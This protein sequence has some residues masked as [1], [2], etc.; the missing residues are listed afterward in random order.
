MTD[1]LH[2]TPGQ[3]VEEQLQYIGKIQHR[4]DHA[5]RGK[6][7]P[8][9]FVDKVYYCEHVNPDGMPCNKL[10]TTRDHV[11]P[12]S[13]ARRL[14]W[15]PDEIGSPDNIQHLCRHHHNGQGG[16]DSDSEARK[17]LLKLQLAGRVNVDYRE[18]KAWIKAAQRAL[19]ERRAKQQ[20][21]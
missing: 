20:T 7:D 8:T 4:N 5:Q 12:R 16:K 19:Y 18:H 21:S 10:G 9:L 14:E 3:P 6:G 13:I 2:P 1:R 15:Q 11:T 17:E